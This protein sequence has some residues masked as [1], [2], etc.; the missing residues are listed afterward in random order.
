VRPLSPQAL[1]QH[2]D[3]I[4]TRLVDSGRI[5]FQDNLSKNNQLRKLVVDLFLPGL[6][7]FLLIPDQAQLRYQEWWEFSSAGWVRF[8]YD[9][10][11]FSLLDQRRRGYHLHPLGG[12]IGV[13]HQIC[14]RSDGQGHGRHYEAFEVD[15][16]AVHEEFEKTY[17][18]DEEFDCRY[19]KSLD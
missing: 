7:D 3:D 1:N 17:A 10:D 15:L 9:Y 8:R 6:E 16:L 14:V 2:F 11:Y 4:Y 18:R 12:R 5:D 13:P 19:L